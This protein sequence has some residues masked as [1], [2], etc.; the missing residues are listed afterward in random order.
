M[1][2]STRI[3]CVLFIPI[4][5]LFRI[6]FEIYSS[7]VASKNFKIYDIFVREDENSNYETETKYK[8]FTQNFF[9]KSCYSNS[10][11]TILYFKKIVQQNGSLYDYKDLNSPCIIFFKKV[12]IHSNKCNIAARLYAKKCDRKCLCSFLVAF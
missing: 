8:N 2:I 6:Y 5:V 1:A 10:L 9:N 3:F 12:S 4:I 11:Q 7:N